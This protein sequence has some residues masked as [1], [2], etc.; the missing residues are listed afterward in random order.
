[1]AGD[2]RA[3]VS[4]YV[5][6][7]ITGEFSDT[8]QWSVAAYLSPSDAQAHAEAAQQRAKAL[9]A[10]C[11]PDCNKPYRRSHGS[12]PSPKPSNEYDPTMRIDYTGTEYDVEEVPL[13]LKFGEDATASAVA[14]F[15]ALQAMSVALD[16]QDQGTR[17]GE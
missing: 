1:M 12:C 4:V 8:R 14:T 2:D 13:R 5:V 16:Q 11:C 15:R 6:M 10:W 7:G 17:S 9:A 3:N